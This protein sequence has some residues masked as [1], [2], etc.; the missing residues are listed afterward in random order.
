[1][2]KNTKKP[3]TSLAETQPIGDTNSATGSILNSTHIDSSSKEP[4]LIDSEQNASHNR[5]ESSKK[6]F[7]I[8]IY[9]LFVIAIGTLIIYLIMNSKETKASINKILNTLSPFTAAFF[10]AYLMHPIVSVIHRFLKRH[11]FQEKA[12][13][14]CKGVS[15]FLSYIFIF[16]LL[17][18]TLIYVVPQLSSSI[19]KLTD[20]LQENAPKIIDTSYEYLNNL[21]HQFP[22]LDL[23]FVE[24]Q[25]KNTIS[26]I[27]A[28]G[29]NLIADTATLLFNL[30][31]SIA[32]LVINTLLALVISCY[33]LSDKKTLLKHL[34]RFIFAVMKEERAARFW[35]TSKECNTIFSKY[36]LGKTLDSVIIG[37]LCFI[38]M[39]ILRLPYTILLSLIVGVTNMIPYFG[40]F[41][42]A[43][44]GILIYLFINPV[45]AVIFAIMILILQQFDGLYLGPK[46]LGEST[47]IKPLWVIFGI[48]VGGA[49]FGPLGMFLGVPVVA[50]IS[51]L[52]NSF[53]LRRLKQ[54]NITDI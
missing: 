50:V 2:S 36:I 42:G 8:S 22:D 30:S 28:L 25:I 39:S 51:Y 45:Q 44:P 3:V 40:P 24:E 19:E 12:Q 11:A 5:F 6:Y 29:P 52:L 27:T 4:N 34:K 10:I 47:G 33:M 20:T 37:I 18:I 38:L 21:E 26:K 48:T 35:Q 41:I 54:K 9:A 32:K 23:G 17:T 13:G 15:I 46:I 43:V 7:T 16:S 53:V 49:Y 14:L 1:M 31:V